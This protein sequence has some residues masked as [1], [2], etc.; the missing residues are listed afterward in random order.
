MASA[1]S[2]PLLCP[3]TYLQRDPWR[4]HLSSH[5]VQSWLLLIPWLALL[6]SSHH[7]SD[8]SGMSSAVPALSWLPKQQQLLIQHYLPQEVCPSLRN[9][10][11]NLW[12]W[13]C[14]WSRVIANCI[15]FKMPLLVFWPGESALIGCINGSTV[16]QTMEVIVGGKESRLS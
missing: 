1:F 7:P 10:W 16:F 15:T 5:Y 3:F 9:Q 4:Q 12:W 11:R 13:V 2:L 8:Y 14:A 6:L